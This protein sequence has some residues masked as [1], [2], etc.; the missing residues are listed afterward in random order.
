MP[1]GFALQLS[2][3]LVSVKVAFMKVLISRKDLKDTT[4]GV[5]KK[6]LQ[7][8]N[9]FSSKGHEAFAIAE[10]LN[11]A[12]V[13]EFGGKPVKTFRWPFSGYFRR[14]FYAQKV[15]A[16]IKSQRPDLI[17]G[18][19]DI[20]HQDILFIHNCVHLA[21]ELIEGKT[22]PVDHEVGRIHS[23]IFNQ[24]S[25]KL[26]VCNSQMMKDD[27]IKRFGVH[28]NKA[29]VIYPEV[30]L[31][32]FKVDHPL[33]VKSAWRE[34]FNFSK[35]DFVIGL[36][37]S[38]NFKKRNLGLLINAFSKFKQKYPE[39]KLFVAG[40][41]IDQ[42]YKEMAPKEGVVFAPSVIDV[43][44]YYYLLDVFVLPAHI[45]EFGRSV[46][47]AMYCGVPVITGKYVGASEI[48]EG[49]GRDYILNELT[50]EK[51]LDLLTRLLDSETRNKIA[52]L[53]KKTAEKYS[54]ER[55]NNAFGEMIKDAGFYV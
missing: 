37:T 23:A 28:G 14:K 35:N 36:I 1:W 43:K 49:E 12:M 3:E 46:L 11:F 24:G 8:L 5:P 22:L 44:N 54:S 40:G 27:L 52:T 15:E 50:E 4:S 45:E 29:V 42:K 13:E 55:Q 31:S 47:E 25:Y 20:F 26:L 18:H 34:K 2:Q 19:G 16:W 51:L 17:I 38:G 9:F 21:H 30:N 6:V 41:N 53:N 7:E 39:A 48:L 33:E 32:K 10:T